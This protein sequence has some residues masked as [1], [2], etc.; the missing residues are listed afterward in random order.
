MSCKWKCLQIKIIS[1]LLTKKTWQGSIRKH[2]TAMYA[3]IQDEL[4]SG[5][6]EPLVERTKQYPQHRNRIIAPIPCPRNV[7]SEVSCNASCVHYSQKVSCICRVIKG[8]RQMCTWI[9]KCLFKPL[10]LFTNSSW[11]ENG[12]KKILFIS[13]IIFIKWKHDSPNHVSFSIKHGTVTG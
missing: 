11:S 4:W 6:L 1:T 8:E 5:W 10:G 13:H 2:L 12:A 7:P 9:F 3:L